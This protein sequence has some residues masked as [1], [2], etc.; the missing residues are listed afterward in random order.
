VRRLTRAALISFGAAAGAVGMLEACSSDDQAAQDAGS[1][2]TSSPEA[3]SG[4]TSFPEAGPVISFA[5]AYG[6]PDQS[7]VADT[8]VPDQSV[9]GDTGAGDQ[10]APDVIL[11]F[12]DAYGV[13]YDFDTGRPDQGAPNGA[14]AEAG[15]MEAE[16]SV[17]DA[18]IDAT[19]DAN[20]EAPEET[21]ASSDANEGGD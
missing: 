5:D 3:G 17:A 9:S 13:A 14:D 19:A 1:G 15:A 4:M 16:A 8:G 6:I 2:M 7:V 21:D 12:A 10:A 18:A 11:S 20:D